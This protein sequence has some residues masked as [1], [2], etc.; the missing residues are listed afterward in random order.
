MSMIKVSISSV[1]NLWESE[2]AP[3]CDLNL[4]KQ[5]GNRRRGSENR[6]G[7]IQ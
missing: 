6:L 2:G 4:G 1:G 7:Q 5:K 3:W